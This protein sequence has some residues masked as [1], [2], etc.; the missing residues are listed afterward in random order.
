MRYA[1]IDILRTFAIFVMVFVHFAE[2]LSGVHSFFTGFGAPLFALL[3]GVSY[4][5]WLNQQERKNV[6]ET[7]ISKV[8]VRRGLF[9]LG[10]GFAFNVLVW[11]PEDTFTWDVLTFIGAAF[12]LMNG[13]RRVPL[14]VSVFVAAVAIVT[15]PL[16]RAM[17]D[18]QAYW[19]NDY[20]EGDLTLTDLVA[21]FLAT[22]YFPIFPWIAFTLTGFVLGSLLFDEPAAV[23]SRRYTSIV[24][25]TGAVLLVVSL[26]ALWAEPGMPTVVAQHVLGGWSMF[27]PSTVYV[28]VMLGLTLMMLGITHHFIDH[29]AVI[30]KHQRW[31]G[32][33]QTFSR[34]S[35]TI[36]ILHH[37]VHLWPLW[38][39]AVA[40]GEEPTIYW[41]QAMPLAWA[42]SLGALFIVCCYVV[43]RLFNK[44]AN[45]GVEAWMRWL[46]D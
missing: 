3:S 32:I 46:C 24:V 1:S 23:D 26:A 29:E 31:I 16:L 40:Q 6:T 4:R 10:V 36:Y 18:Y 8:S 21:G 35:F 43:L 41:M 39:Y 20:F 7:Q 45:H 9:I 11:L 42:M 22:G 34:N 27:P 14:P 33:A 5:L 12:L 30:A 15:S 25:T 19:V 17:A 38:I 2:N 28:L 37:I 13:L 44:D